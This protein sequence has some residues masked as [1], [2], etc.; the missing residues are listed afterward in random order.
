MYSFTSSGLAVLQ[1]RSKVLQFFYYSFDGCWF[2][3]FF[4]H[5]DYYVCYVEFSYVFGVL[6]SPV[7][8]V[9]RVL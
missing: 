7:G 1:F 6:G 8:V 5:P 3:G 9:L 4:F 2:V